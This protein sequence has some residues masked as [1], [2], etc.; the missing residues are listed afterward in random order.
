LSFNLNLKFKPTIVSNP[1]LY[2]LVAFIALTTIK[3]W[4]PFIHSSAFVLYPPIHLD[5]PTTY[6]SFSSVD[7][8][9]DHNTMG[10]ISHLYYFTAGCKTHITGPMTHH[11]AG[12]MTH[13]LN[14]FGC[15][16][17]DTSY[18]LSQCHYCL[19]PGCMSSSSMQWHGSITAGYHAIDK[20]F[21]PS[22]QCRHIMAHPPHKQWKNTE[23]FQP[24]KSPLC[25]LLAINRSIYYLLNASFS[26]A[27]S[28]NHLIHRLLLRLQ[29]Y[30][31]RHN[32]FKHYWFTLLLSGLLQLVV[33]GHCCAWQLRV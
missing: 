4:I 1:M 21:Y 20:W 23:F 12:C 17:H 5:Y 27:Y 18:A 33:V 10:S 3:Q 26:Q 11:N 32:D 24:S 9:L 29:Q 7:R 8:T 14:I 30:M 15:A 16:T 28:V 19:A 25:L 22:C 2:F 6:D 31:T 13:N